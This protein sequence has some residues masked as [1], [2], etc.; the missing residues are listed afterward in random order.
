MWQGCGLCPSETRSSEQGDDDEESQSPHDIEES[1]TG[2]RVGRRGR[3][4]G[5]WNS[6]GRGLHQLG[7]C[8]NPFLMQHDVY[9]MFPGYR[10][11]P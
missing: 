1:R 10:I 7:Q 4:W 11:S 9:L 8:E 2:M 5:S 3:R 6:V